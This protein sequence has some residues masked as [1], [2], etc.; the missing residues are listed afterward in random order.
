MWLSGRGVKT[1]LQIVLIRLFAP[2]MDIQLVLKM[3]KY[4]FFIKKYF[5]NQTLGLP[6]LY[7]GILCLQ[8]EEVDGAVN[9]TWCHKFSIGA[10]HKKMNADPMQLYH[11]G[12]NQNDKH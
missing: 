5:L 12:D 4:I 1:Q 8:V 11:R 3:K 6:N 7:H 9:S 2:R 10:L